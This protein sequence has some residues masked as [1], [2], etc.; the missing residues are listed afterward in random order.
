MTYRAYV[1]SLFL[2]PNFRI[3]SKFLCRLTGVI[4]YRF[5]VKYCHVSLLSREVI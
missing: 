3:K 4:L 2:F 1:N 5:S